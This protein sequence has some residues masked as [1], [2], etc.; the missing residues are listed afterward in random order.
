MRKT[1]RGGLLGPEISSEIK[2]NAK[3]VF[4]RIK[5][6]KFQDNHLIKKT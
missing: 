1:G 3:I 2:I 6:S 4:F 5:S